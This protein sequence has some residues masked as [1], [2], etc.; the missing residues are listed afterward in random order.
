MAVPGG[1][2]SVSNLVLQQSGQN[3]LPVL[4]DGLDTSEDR[5]D[6]DTASDIENADLDDSTDI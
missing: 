4:L 6:T 1:P 5:E 3:T 2:A